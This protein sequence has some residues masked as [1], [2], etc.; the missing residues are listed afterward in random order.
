LLLQLS[1]PVVFYVCMASAAASDMLSMT[2]AN[3]FSILLVVAFAALAPFTGMD[4]AAYFWHLAAGAIVLAVTFLLFAVGAMGGGDAKLLAAT[5]VWMG[6][7]LPLAH[8]F[9][10]GAMLGG[11]L[12]LVLLALRYSP[13]AAPAGN[14]RLFRHLADRN[15]GIPYGIAL[16]AAGLMAFPSSPLGAWALAQM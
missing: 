1:L 9:I 4:P 14:T 16:G 12:T 2:I 13:I 8:Y 15:A 7:G 6:P 10:W 3:R 5:A 11:V